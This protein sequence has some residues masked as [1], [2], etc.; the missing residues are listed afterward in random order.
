MKQYYEQWL[1][2]MRTDGRKLAVYPCPSCTVS[3]ETLAPPKDQ[4]YD[5]LSV[6]PHCEKMHFKVVYATGQVESQA[7]A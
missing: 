3:I 4:I 5:S 7:V 6:C 2:Q 1:E